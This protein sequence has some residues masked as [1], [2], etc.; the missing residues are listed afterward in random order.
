VV[1]SMVISI[2]QYMWVVYWFDTK[3]KLIDTKFQCASIDSIWT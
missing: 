3:L 1:A 2:L